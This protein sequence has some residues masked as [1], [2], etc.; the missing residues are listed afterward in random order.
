ML[1]WY[2]AGE[3]YRVLIDDCAGLVRDA[4]TAVG[5]REVRFQGQAL[6]SLRHLAGVERGRRLAEYAG[7]DLLAAYD[8]TPE[9]IRRRWPRRRP[10]PGFRRTTAIAGRIFSSG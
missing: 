3:G 8:G 4:L 7:I 2:R 9:R 5:R 10:G 1:E 6:R